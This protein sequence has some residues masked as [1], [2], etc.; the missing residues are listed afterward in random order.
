MVTRSV[1]TYVTRLALVLLSLAAFLCILCLADILLSWDVFE[2]NL[3]KFAVLIVG[4]VFVLMLS[5]IAISIMLNL[6]LLS[7]SVERVLG[8]KELR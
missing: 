8:S 2:P 7:K 4:A 6:S 5:T 3:Q 1:E